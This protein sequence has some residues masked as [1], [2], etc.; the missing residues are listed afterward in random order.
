VASASRRQPDAE[1]PRF[2]VDRGL[3]KVHVPQ[4]FRTA[5]LDVVL[6]SDLYPD[7]ADQRVGDDQWIRE[8]SALGMVALTKDVAIVRAHVDALRAS[9]LRVFA[10]PNANLTGPEMARRF[11]VNLHRIL[12]RS[13]RGGPFVD[14]IEPST[15]SRRW[16]L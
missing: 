8:V 15:V 13:R 5:G 10:L 4:V 9:T 6:M 14:V 11:E 12:Q 1:P 7:G 16:P 2:F 3:G